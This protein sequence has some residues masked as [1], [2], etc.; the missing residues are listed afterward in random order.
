MFISHAYFYCGMVA[1]IVSRALKSPIFRDKAKI[2]G[3]RGL[4]RSVLE[5]YRQ[6]GR[7][8]RCL[9]HPNVIVDWDPRSDFIANGYLILGASTPGISH[10]ELN[11]SKFSVEENATIRVSCPGR[12]ASIGPGSV[13]HVE[14]EF[15]IGES[16]IT[17]NAR[18]ICE[19]SI[20]IGNHCAISWDVTILDSDRHTYYRN[21]EKQAMTAPISIGDDVWIGHNATIGKGVTIS[22]GAI[23]SSNSVVTRDVPTKTLVA[24]IPA[25]PIAQNVE[26]DSAWQ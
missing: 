21:G 4:V 9:I 23:V 24:G 5:S 26:W 2:L 22:D 12:M 25:E 20:T 10:P 6:S 8:D 1:D 11:K 3:L 15:S 14:G 18:V 13:I 17:A 16:S 19:D 7:I